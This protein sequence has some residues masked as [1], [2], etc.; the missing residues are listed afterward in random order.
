MIQPACEYIKYYCPIF[1]V[2]ENKLADTG[3]LS[4]FPP[5]PKCCLL[6]W[7]I[8]L[9]IDFCQIYNPNYSGRLQVLQELHSESEASLDNLGRLY[10]KIKA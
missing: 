1:A 6:G 7:H 9:N 4:S 5:L 8:S 3:Y 2:G 10:L